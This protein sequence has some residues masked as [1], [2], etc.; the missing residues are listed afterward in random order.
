[1][2][3]DNIII[4]EKIA[5]LVRELGGR[6][7]YVG[8]MVR[9]ELLGIEN[10]DADIEVH[11]ITPAQLESILDSLGEKLK[12]G[13]SFGIYGLRGY[14]IDIAMPRTEQA[15]GRGHRDFEVFVD[16]FLGVQKAA[17]RRDFTV[18]ALMKDVLTGEITDS[19]GGIDDLKNGVL[20]H[21]NDKTFVEDPLR[22]LRACQFAARFGFEIAPETVEIMKTMSLDALAKERVLGE[23][24]K[25][26]LKAE[27]PSV[28]FEELRKEEQLDFWFPELKTL[29][30]LEQPLNWHP[31]GDVFNH[32]MLVLDA[33]A[34]LKDGA[35]N[36]SGFMLA[37]L[38]HDFGK[39]TTQ[40]NEN[41]KITFY[42]HETAGIPITETFLRRLTD[43]TDLIKY[44][45]NLCKLH[46]RPN[47]LA[48]FNSGQKALNRLFYQCVDPQG[49]VLLAKADALGCKGR[50]LN[51]AIQE[52]LQNGLAEYNK[53][54]EKP[55]VLGADLI[56]AGLT[57]G[58]YFSELL[59]YATKLRLA[60]T[61]KE[62][63]LTQTLAYA[64]QKGYFN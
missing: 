28:F 5:A 1:M 11:G 61:E 35:E 17:M 29:I 18:N 62:N 30:G 46:M 32:T 2:S 53:T 16:P 63:A 23:L 13:A 39:A 37:A 60:G 26:L 50:E 19:F 15:T 7:Y 44:T 41:G 33:A 49:L 47:Q 34:S 58:A 64:K 31:E 27:R 59:D 22:A 21:V 6:T 51:P 38:C 45:L 40:K 3:G 52:Y 14:D 42:G 4:A 55:A 8:G 36:R 10:K 24:K 48:A 56:K 20:R 9:D 25:A 54:M 43:E 57:P 12:I